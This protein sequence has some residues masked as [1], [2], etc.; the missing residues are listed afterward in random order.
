MFNPIKWF[1]SINQKCSQAIAKIFPNT[2]FDI[3]A[4]D[5]YY[6]GQITNALFDG[7][8]VVD[9]GG[10]RRCQFQNERQRYTGVKVI[11][12][13]ISEEEL[14]LNNDADEKIVFAL[15]SDAPLPIDDSSVDVVTSQMVL[16]HIFNNDNSVREISRIL[17]PGGK[18]IS[19]MP[20][21]FA[22]FS[23]INQILPH[24]FAKK[25]LYFFLN[26]PE[27]KDIQGFKAYYNKTY[28]P[29]IQKL[30]T[31]YGFSDVQ[32][33]LCYHQSG[34]FEF[35]VPFALI[36]LTWDCLMY[37]FGIKPFCAYIVFTA[38]K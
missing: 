34:Y 18:F 19:L 30:L 25:V 15:G 23:I 21:K 5:E 35:F 14:R 28:Y 12:V 6:R 17:K 16:E 33:K 3:D 29:A 36:S 9:V 10:G 11:A 38:V 27:A 20:N 24:A 1:F 13:D 37:L 4:L 8:R 2:K 26:K 7:C 32:F 31:K 22:L